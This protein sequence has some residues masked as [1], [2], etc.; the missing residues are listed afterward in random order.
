MKNFVQKKNIR[1]GANNK[2]KVEKIKIALTFMLILAVVGGG[3]YWIASNADQEK[4][5]RIEKVDEGYKYA[6][7]IITNIHAY[8][9]H[10]I[11][12][13]YNI[14][15]KDYEYAG[16]WD[17]NPKKLNV[18]DSISFRYWIS[19]PKFIVTELETKY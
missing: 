5:D 4:K 9:G 15:G 11:E 2:T 12:I 14:D 18:N 10:S 17:N 19:D 6:R 3:L 7:G 1:E 8:K 13:K 16:G